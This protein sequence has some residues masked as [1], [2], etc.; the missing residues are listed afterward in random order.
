MI[1]HL[2]SVRLGVPASTRHHARRVRETCFAVLDDSLPPDP[3]LLPGATRDSESAT[4]RSRVSGCG[5]TLSF[6]EFSVFPALPLMS[7]DKSP[8]AG[9]LG[10]HLISLTVCTREATATS[11]ALTGWRSSDPRSSWSAE[12]VTL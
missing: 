7:A 4:G 11:T 1:I 6:S 2:T 9:V 12:L 10:R 3:V 8:L 5:S